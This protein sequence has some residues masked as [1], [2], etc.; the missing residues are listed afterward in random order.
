MAFDLRVQH[1]RRMLY[2][3]DPETRPSSKLRSMNR[4]ASGRCGRGLFESGHSP[5]RTNLQNRLVS[6]SPDSS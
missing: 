2:A 1:A 3:L 5:A 4:R 6:P